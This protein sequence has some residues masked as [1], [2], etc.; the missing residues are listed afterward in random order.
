MNEPEAANPLESIRDM[1]R[2][3]HNAATEADQLDQTT[4]Y[5]GDRSGQMERYA[6]LENV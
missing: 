3:D 1:E 6:D 4:M 2:R 5:H